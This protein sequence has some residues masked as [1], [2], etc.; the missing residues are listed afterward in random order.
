M[1]SNSPSSRRICNYDVFLSFRGDDTRN[2]FTDHLYN[3]LIRKGIFTFKDDKR[4]EKG[5]PISSQLLQAI[6]DSRVS[7]VIFSRDYAASTWCLEEMAAIVDCHKELKQIV[8]PVF[9]DVDPSHVRKQDGAY[10]DAFA[11]HT[12]RFKEVPDKVD[13]WKRAMVGLANSVGW[14]VRDKYVHKL[15]FL[16]VYAFLTRTAGVFHSCAS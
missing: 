10:E 2:N 13:R 4:L 14:D 6:R 9:Y 12:E 11:V 1:D 3:H 5:Q 16:L 8:F 7:I 15:S